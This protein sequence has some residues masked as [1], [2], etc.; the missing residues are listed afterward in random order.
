MHCRQH[1]N[2][3]E[4]I[5]L[6]ETPGVYNF[7]RSAFCSA[8]CTERLS[9]T[10]RL[11]HKGTRRNSK[12]KGIRTEF[13]LINFARA[14]C[15]SKQGERNREREREERRREKREREGGGMGKIRNIIHRY[16]MSGGFVSET[17]FRS[18]AEVFPSATSSS[19]TSLS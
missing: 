12:R 17:Y 2:N 3:F 4:I 6:N 5:K 13:Q 16:R 7:T 19:D 15:E 1:G 10:K 9:P 11:I 18:R 14:T 8:N